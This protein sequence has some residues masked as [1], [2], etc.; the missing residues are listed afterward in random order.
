MGCLAGTWRATSLSYP[1]MEISGGG[2]AVL[3]VS[4]SGIF[5]MNED[6][7]TPMTISYNGINGT[8]RYKGLETGKFRV[9]GDKLSGTTR[10]S[11]FSVS[12]QI[13]GVSVKS[14]VPQVAA[15][16]TVP[17]LSFSCS[18]DKLTLVT[19]QGSTWHFTRTS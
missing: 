1:S 8:M 2:G 19:A 14:P 12:T 16:S 11:T 4:K 17:W 13:N 18:G 10:T 7:A 15:G 6:T 3:M 5:T 9:T